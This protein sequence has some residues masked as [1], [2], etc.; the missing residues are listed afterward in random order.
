MGRQV[1]EA[2]LETGRRSWWVDR[3]ESWWG[4]RKKLLVVRQVRAAG[5]AV[6]RQVEEAI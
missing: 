6:G 1:G 2:D 4:E 3:K 5:E